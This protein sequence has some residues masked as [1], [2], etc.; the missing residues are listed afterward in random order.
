MT[1]AQRLGIVQHPSDYNEQF[2]QFE[3]YLA[4]G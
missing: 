3:A 4:E 2:A 1:A